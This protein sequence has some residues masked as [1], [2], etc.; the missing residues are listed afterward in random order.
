MAGR[1]AEKDC[2]EVLVEVRVLPVGYSFAHCFPVPRNAQI[3]YKKGRKSLIWLSRNLVR[4]VKGAATALVRTA[5]QG[6]TTSE[7]H[8]LSLLPVRE[9]AI[10]FPA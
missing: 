5:C 9:E 3:M 7:P 10:V 6:S 8:G 2:L 4:E 1:A